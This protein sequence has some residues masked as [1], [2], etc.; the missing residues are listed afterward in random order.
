MG[1]WRVMPDLGHPGTRLPLW[2]SNVA[3]VRLL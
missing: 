3:G 1:L 2:H